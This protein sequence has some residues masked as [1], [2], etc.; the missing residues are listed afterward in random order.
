LSCENNDLIERLLECEKEL[1]IRKEDLDTWTHSLEEL[2]EIKDA[3]TTDGKINHLDKKTILDIGTDCVKPL[4][5]ALKFK[6]DKIIGIN[7]ELFI[8]FAS[9]LEQKSKLLIAPT[10]IRLYDCSLFNKETLDKILEE[11]GIE[12]FDFVLVSKT[13][14]H[15]RT[16]KCVAKERDEEHK[17]QEDEECC[18]YEFEEQKIFARLL[19]MGKRVIVYEAFVPQE[20]DNDKVRGRGAH[21]TTKE[22]KKTFETL[23]ER[24]RVE[25]VR[26]RQFHLNK[27]TLNKVDSILRQ[28]DCICFYVEK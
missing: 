27:K 8:S 16:G 15:L 3:F 11:E 17:C 1:E 2:S 12:R 28:V 23:L 6:P 22:L 4:Y 13:L 18:I 9:D 26:P 7:E 21:F 10:T 19:E 5:I 24:Y 25:F 20:K 14:H